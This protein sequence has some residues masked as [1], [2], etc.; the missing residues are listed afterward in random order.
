[1]FVTRP[2]PNPTPLSPV[3]T[4]ETVQSSNA[5]PDAVLRCLE[6][7]SSD[8]IIKIARGTTLPHPDSWTAC[9]WAPVIDGVELLDSPENLI[10]AGKVAPG[11]EILIGV[12]ADEGSSF[13]GYNK[14]GTLDTPLPYNLSKAKLTEWVANSFS[15]GDDD[16]DWLLQRYA[17]NSSSSDSARYWKAAEK[18]VGDYMMVCPTRRASFSDGG[19]G[20]QQTWCKIPSK[21]NATLD[22]QPRLP[23]RGA[24]ADAGQGLQLRLLRNAGHDSLARR[25]LSR[26]GDPVCLLFRVGTRR[27]G[28]EDSLL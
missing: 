4:R 3:H 6:A 19:C 5:D 17:S 27:L 20:S 28:G 22:H 1:M 25:R 24:H 9:Q 16:V 11:I 10:K 12:N 26:S 8:E 21:L 15:L 23:A 2:T 13:I 7:K 14:T 18:M